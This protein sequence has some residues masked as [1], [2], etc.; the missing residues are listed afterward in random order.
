MT[1]SAELAKKVRI[2][3]SSAEFRQWLDDNHVAANE[4]WVGFYNRSSADR[5]ITY[6]EARDDALCYG[7]IDGVRKRVNDATYTIRFTPRKSRSIW[8]NVNIQRVDELTRLGKMRPA[9]LAAF[10]QRPAEN[11]KYSYEREHAELTPAQKKQFRANSRAWEFYQ[12]QA[13][14]YR[15]TSSWWVI[16]AK[17]EQTQQRRLKTLIADSAAGRRLAMLTNKSK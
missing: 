5:S 13:P 2:F 15:R 4:L 10:E 17:Q 6:P 1:K 12:A 14:W 9:G 8:S 16:S 7:W 3:H 11:S